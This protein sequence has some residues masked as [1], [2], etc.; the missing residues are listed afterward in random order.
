MSAHFSKYS[1]LS[2]P[3]SLKVVGIIGGA[4]AILVILGAVIAYLSEH[5]GFS[6]FTT[7]LSDIG[8]T[9]GWPQII[10]NSSTLIA[11]PIRYLVLVL[12]VLR[13]AQLGAGRPFTIATLFSSSLERSL[14]CQP[15]N[16]ESIALTSK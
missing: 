13:L 11:V 1:M 4:W 7:Y 14:P 3:R 10:F 8:D 16:I 6:P 15:T 9:L 2:I 5:P 12:P